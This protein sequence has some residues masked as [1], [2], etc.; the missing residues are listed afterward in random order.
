MLTDAGQPFY[1]KSEIG[2][3]FTW[4][5]HS[6]GNQSAS[7]QTLSSHRINTIRQRTGWLTKQIP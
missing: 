2:N 5:W 1:G 3:V 6:Q 7:R 4:H